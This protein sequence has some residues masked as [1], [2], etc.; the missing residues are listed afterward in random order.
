M[1]E[2]IL[3]RLWQTHADFTYKHIYHE[4][5]AKIEDKVIVMLSKRLSIFGMINPQQTNENELSDEILRETNY[6]IPALQQQV[7]GF[8]PQ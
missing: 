8:V 5:L 2:D 6:D 4:A 7:A 3:Q 1:L